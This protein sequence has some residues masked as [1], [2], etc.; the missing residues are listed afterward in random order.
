MTV[1]S[2]PS[3]GDLEAQV[4]LIMSGFIWRDRGRH[5]RTVFAA[6]KFAQLFAEASQKLNAP[7]SPE[8]KLLARWRNDFEK[9]SDAAT[10]V[11]LE[12]RWAGADYIYNDSPTEDAIGDIKRLAKV[13]DDARPL[14]GEYGPALNRYAVTLRDA[15]DESER[16]GQAAVRLAV[17][18]ERRKEL[19]WRVPMS[20]L[21]VAGIAYLW[22][23]PLGLW[24]AL[25]F[26]ACLG[27][28]KSWKRAEN[29]EAEVARRCKQIGWPLWP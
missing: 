4:S 29:Q 25:G 7:D 28:L 17:K 20:A 2:V 8:G 13:I 3:R 23:R 27:V 15:L 16:A 11:F 18:L 14:A 22:G 24:V 9:V 5:Q 26:I 21:A 1:D 19:L 10:F 12:S 6:G